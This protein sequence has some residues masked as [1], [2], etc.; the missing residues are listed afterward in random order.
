VNSSSS[1]V[2]YFVHLN[3]NNTGMR[4]T[5][6]KLCTGNKSI[7]KYWTGRLRGN[8]RSMR[9]APPLSQTIE[10]QPFSTYRSR[11]IKK[12]PKHT[13]QNYGIIHSN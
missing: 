7:I 6:H 8:V 5:K 3:N 13:S 10:L 4:K 11:T 12:S 2:Y 9:Q 1:S